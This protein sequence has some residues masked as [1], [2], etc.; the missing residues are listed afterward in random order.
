MNYEIKI[1]KYQL[2]LKQTNNQEKINYYNKKINYYKNKNKPQNGGNKYDIIESEISIE[3][4]T[5]NFSDIGND[6]IADLYIT[7]MV[8][9]VNNNDVKKISDLKNDNINHDK[10]LSQ[11]IINK[12]NNLS[13]NK[14]LI[15]KIK[16]EFL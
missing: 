11:S 10:D 14:K 2:K 9:A 12:L 6:F 15:N 5:M 4:D 1:K 3:N 8:S 13:I 16:E 7:S